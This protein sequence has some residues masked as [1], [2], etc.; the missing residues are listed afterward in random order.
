MPCENVGFALNSITDP[1]KVSL[2]ALLCFFENTAKWSLA[3]GE[4]WNYHQVVYDPIYH[5]IIMSYHIA[6]QVKK[7][8]KRQR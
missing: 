3:I 8:K 2:F 6:I 7:K 1:G 4:K 5:I